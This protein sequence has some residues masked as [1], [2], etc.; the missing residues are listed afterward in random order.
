MNRF[1]LVFDPGWLA[2]IAARYNYPG[3]ARIIAD[4]KSAKVRGHY[5]YD[6]FVRLYRWKT[7]GRPMRRLERN[8]PAEV[9]AATRTALDGRTR[10]P[11]RAAALVTLAG[12]EYP[13]ASCVLHFAHSGPVAE[14]ATGPY[15]WETSF[16]VSC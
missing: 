14:S 15:A 16:Q 5:L 11:R 9:E 6:E 7:R 8:D 12:I 4:G 13:V 1:G 10:E 3:E 2:E